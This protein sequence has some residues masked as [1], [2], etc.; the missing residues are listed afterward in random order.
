MPQA[1]FFSCW[2]LG[3]GVTAA[4]YLRVFTNPAAA[5]EALAASEVSAAAWHHAGLASP[6]QPVHQR[7]ADD[8]AA[9]RSVQCPEPSPLI[10]TVKRCAALG[11]VSPV[12]MFNSSAISPA[13]F[14]TSSRQSSTRHL[15]ESSQVERTGSNYTNYT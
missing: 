14:T 6:H 11:Q 2:P 10:N 12:R 3:M 4:L 7:S 13:R 5:F 15:A 9:L 8:D 1:L